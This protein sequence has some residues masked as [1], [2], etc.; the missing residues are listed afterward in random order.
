MAIPP[1]AIR[2][3]QFGCGPIGCRIA[4]LVASKKHLLLVG[5]VD[6]QPGLGGRDIGDVA[7]AEP[8]GAAIVG[9]WS[10]LPPSA[11][12]QIA[13]HTTASSLAVVAP[14]LHALIDV[15]VDVVS[16]C[17]ELSYPTGPNVDIATA[18]HEAAVAAGVSVLGTGI[19]PGYL[20]DAWPLFMTAPCQQVRSISAT[21]VQDA[22]TRRGPFQAKI[23]AGLSDT[24]F[25][26]RA[27][28]GAIRHVGLTESIGMIAAGLDW[29]LQETTEAIEPVMADHD[30]E[31]EFVSVAA[32][33]VAGV[34]Q[35]GVGWIAGRQAITLSFTAAVG[36][37]QSYDEVAIDGVPPLQARIH[38]GVHGDIGTAAVVVNA[39]R[40]VVTAAPGLITMKDLPVPAAS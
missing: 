11:E 28:T 1:K 13:V 14:Q 8:L 16:T 9:S 40:R 7:G 30:V 15:G 27:A 21:R 2:V 39:L 36:L 24:E 31:T 5:G 25:R 33:G 38:G 23:G 37:G 29:V 19:N 20:M 10:E 22:S 4:Q 18:L 34:T 6:I 26:D 12:P 32:G 35:T 17:E 3:V